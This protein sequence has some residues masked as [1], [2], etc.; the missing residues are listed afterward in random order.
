M[1]P[2]KEFEWIIK[3]LNSEFI[4]GG[5][6]RKRKGGCKSDFER[7][8]GASESCKE[9]RKWLDFLIQNGILEFFEKKRIRNVK[10]IDTYAVNYDK[11][12]KLLEKNPLYSLAKRV[13]D[14]DRII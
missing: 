12:K 11:L 6:F 14:K 2:E 13:F 5:I 8:V 10:E 4:K 1:K 3:L 7:E 9:F